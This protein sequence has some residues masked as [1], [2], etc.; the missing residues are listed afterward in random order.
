MK[1]DRAHAQIQPGQVLLLPHRQGNA[2]VNRREHRASLADAGD[3]FCRLGGRNP[4]PVRP[5]AGG[6]AAVWG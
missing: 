3:C 5:A 6:F 2:Q 1:P 4:S